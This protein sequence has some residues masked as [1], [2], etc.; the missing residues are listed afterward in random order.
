MAWVERLD[1]NPRRPV[2]LVSA[3]ASAGAIWLA[4]PPDAGQAPTAISSYLIGRFFWVLVGAAA[5]IAAAPEG[6]LSVLQ[7][8][9]VLLITCAYAFD[10]HGPAMENLTTAAIWGLSGLLA[11]RLPLERVA[12]RRFLIVAVTV[13]MVLG[14]RRLSYPQGILLLQFLFVCEL[15]ARRP[16]RTWLECQRASSVAFMN[17]PPGDLIASTRAVSSMWLGA[18]LL[19]A[20][21]LAERAFVRLAP[22]DGTPLYICEQSMG[23]TLSDDVWKPLTLSSA[24]VAVPRLGLWLWHLAVNYF[25]FVGVLRLLGVPVSMPMGNLLRV[26]NLFDYWKAVNRWRYA[27]LKCV[28]IDHFFPLESGFLGTINLIAVFLVSGLHHAVGGL[29]RTGSLARALLWQSV[30]WLISGVLCSI[31]LQWVL[32]RMRKRMRAAV[33]GLPP[34]APRP[35]VRIL[36][37]AASLS[38]VLLVMGLLLS[39]EEVFGATSPFSVVTGTAPDA[40][41]FMPGG[42]AERVSGASTA[43]RP[44]IASN[45]RGIYVAFRGSSNDPS[46]WWSTRAG[47]AWTTARPLGTARSPWPPALTAT[48][49]GL[50]AAWTGEDGRAGIRWALF[51]QDDTWGP[52]V[53]LP[54][55]RAIGEPA[56]A[57]DGDTL[58]AA[59]RGA[60]GGIWWTRFDPANASPAPAPRRV[61]DWD[62]SASPA[63]GVVDDVLYALWKGADAEP[64]A[65]WTSTYNG[66]AWGPRRRMD[67]IAATSAPAIVVIDHRM[68]L[69]WR[70]ADWD[71]DVHFTDLVD[72]VWSK[73]VRTSINSC[74]GPGVAAYRSF[75]VVATRGVEST[76]CSDSDFGGE[77]DVSS[78]W[79]TGIN[80]TMR[81]PFPIGLAAP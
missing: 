15:M 2:T 56:L 4:L 37:G 52:A 16:R 58:Y 81:V 69:A 28:Y 17:A 1:A 31:T 74:S 34:T 43:A 71:P 27:L 18:A 46:L 51:H 24:L 5:A 6:W 40:H 55:A 42:A 62:T 47:S 65:L 30:P 48:P 11:W 78:L 45:D 67:G 76:R 80:L 29:G 68:V 50:A 73:E 7:G 53:S 66:R 36:G 63:I 25:A 23:L 3:A 8:V 60:E 19:V 70:G 75:L 21:L 9:T 32:H 59:W 79:V 57:A 41:R 72:G 13:G 64:T 12:L 77:W 61:G 39:G 44:S 14:A 54:G 35:V 10:L 49:R 22:C 38:A 20:V 26:R 33:L